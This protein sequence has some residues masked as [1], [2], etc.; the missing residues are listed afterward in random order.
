M[1]K[2]MR[3]YL[4]AMGI[5]LLIGAVGAFVWIRWAK[6]TRIAFA[7]YPEYMLAPMLDQEINPAIEVTSLKW[8][9]KSGNEL[10]NFD[11]VLFFGMGLN[12]TEQQQ[13]ILKNL[14]TKFWQ[15]KFRNLI[16]L[17][18]DTHIQNLTSQL[19]MEIHISYL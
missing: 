15:K 16:S 18:V 2:K 11:F 7:N 19:F 4:L 12:F 1:S 9:E 8:T 14:K 3:K 6:P 17:L 13:E 10:K 5:I